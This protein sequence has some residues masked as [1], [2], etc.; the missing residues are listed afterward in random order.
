MNSGFS[1]AAAWAKAKPCETPRSNKESDRIDALREANPGTISFPRMAFRHGGSPGG[2]NR[3]T[4]AGDSPALVGL[5]AGRCAWGEIIRA[6]FL[7][8]RGPAQPGRDIHH[9]QTGEVD[10]GRKW[11]LDLQKTLGLTIPTAQLQAAYGSWRRLT[12]MAPPTP[13]PPSRK[14]AGLADLV[15][16]G[17]LGDPWNVTIPHKKSVSRTGWLTERPMTARLNTSTGKHQVFTK[18]MHLAFSRLAADRVTFRRRSGNGR[19]GASLAQAWARQ[20]TLRHR[21]GG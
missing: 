4:T 13:V 7:V 5:D 19:N 2:Q 1:V 14:E 9:A 16:R 18:Y 12:C 20:A 10:R 17:V 3:V 11:D 15:Q 8:L 6:S 21:G